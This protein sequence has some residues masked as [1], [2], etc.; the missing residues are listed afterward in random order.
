M[1]YKI[2]HF[3]WNLNLGGA[4]MMLYNFLTVADRDRFDHDVIVMK[5]TGP[6]GA[7]IAELGIAVN[8]ME[9]A[10]NLRFLS[11]LQRYRRHLRNR[12]PSAIQ[13]WMYVAD[14][15]G[16][17]GSR[18]INGNIPVAWGVHHIADPSASRIASAS[19]RICR[20]LANS[21]IAPARIV[22]CSDIVRDTHAGYGYPAHLLHVIDNGIDTEKFIPCP[23]AGSDF[24]DRHSIP[25]DAIVA[26][27]AARFHPL[28]D[29]GT[30]IKAI[31]ILARNNPDIHFAAC[32]REIDSSNHHLAALIDATGARDR[33]HLL[34][35]VDDITGFQ[36]SLDIGVISTKGE[37]FSLSIA[38]AMACGVPCVATD[39]PGGPRT[40]IVG[41]TGIIIPPVDVAA[42]SD[43]LGELL[44]MS[45]GERAS[46]GNRA[47][48]RIVDNYDIRATAR[49]YEQLY[50]DMI[51]QH[52]TTSECSR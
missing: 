8:S 43:A 20:S 38:E 29:Y 19:M 44:A 14:A 28:K 5:D 11:A 45:P 27:M 16:L 46:L 22:C 24:R 6:V 13:T 36:A 42:M 30:V 31:G 39:D 21:P 9:S 34:G 3:V 7:M 50:A 4:E 41:D 15:V 32:G 51:R 48:Q 17:A 35:V 49:K 2:S 10:R 52:Q 37:S 12:T 18:L 33:F 25:R 47:R 40:K 26:G 1:K 23:A